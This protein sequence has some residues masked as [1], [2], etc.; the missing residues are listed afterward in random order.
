MCRNQCS[1]DVKQEVKEHG[2]VNASSAFTDIS[3]DQTEAEC[4]TALDHVHMVKTEKERLKQIGEPEAEVASCNAHCNTTEDQLFAKVI[5]SSRPA[6]SRSFSYASS[7][8][9]KMAARTEIR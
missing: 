1:P 2:I 3:Q 6:A 8:L 7:Q 9:G 4:I 5:V